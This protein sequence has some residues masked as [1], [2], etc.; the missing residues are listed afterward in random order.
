MEPPAS[1]KSQKK[2]CCM[3]AYYSPWISHFSDKILKLS[4]NIILPPPA[5]VTDTF[6]NLK[7]ELESAVLTMVNPKIPLT[8]ES[9]ASDLAISA[10]LNQEGRPVTILF[11]NTIF[12]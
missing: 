3:F 11:L 4:E 7:K 6:N 1:L 8:V 9:D 12:K 2:A 10:T 5:E